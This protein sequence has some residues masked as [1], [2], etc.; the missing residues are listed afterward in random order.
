MPNVPVDSAHQKK[1]NLSPARAQFRLAVHSFMASGEDACCTLFC[2]SRT[3]WPT[4]PG[5]IF[6]GSPAHQVRYWRCCTWPHHRHYGH[7]RLARDSATF[8][9]RASNL[10]HLSSRL[11][12]STRLCHLHPPADLLHRLRLLMTARHQKLPAGTPSLASVVSRYRQVKSET[13]VD[14]CDKLADGAPHN[15][16]AI[17]DIGLH[18]FAMHTCAGL[19]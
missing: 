8:P 18:N 15:S 10:G 9:A 7:S 14:D 5:L 2:T 11:A 1:G 4:V 6:I 12:Q 19:G 3:Q 16:Q 17:A 13:C